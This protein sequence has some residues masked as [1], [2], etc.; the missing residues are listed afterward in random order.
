MGRATE[1]V[2]PLHRTPSPA[3]CPG[4]WV[5]YFSLA[6]LPLFGLGQLF[7]PNNDVNARQYVFKLLFVYTASGL[8]LLLSTSFLG[9]RRYLRQRRQEMPLRMVNLWLGTG[10][11]LIVA[12]MFAAMLLPRPNAEYAIS[13]LP[14]HIGSPRPTQFALRHGAGG[15]RG[16]PAR[17]S[18]RTARRREA[19]R[20]QSDQ[21][22]DAKSANGRND[23]SKSADKDQKASNDQQRPDEPGEKG[24][25]RR[26]APN[27]PQEKRSTSE[28][29]PQDDQAKDKAGQPPDRDTEK[30]KPSQRSGSAETQP[31]KKL[32]E[33]SPEQRKG[34]H[35]AVLQLT[36]ECRSAPHMSFPHA[37]PSF[38]GGAEMAV[39][40]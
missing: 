23:N 20:T 13:D 31:L 29:Q 32:P 16:G 33:K 15:C 17:R 8:G 30:T 34:G 28:K 38:G 35:A 5:V 37:L 9:M 11:A 40:I 2:G 22:G 27:Q 3:P 39:C 24:E 4:V 1:L 6:A 26:Q 10:V 25:A 12:V 7:I 18:P 14:I 21:P 36:R 19:Q